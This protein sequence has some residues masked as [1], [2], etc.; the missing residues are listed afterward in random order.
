GHELLE[1]VKPVILLR[2]AKYQL[3]AGTKEKPK[4]G[5]KVRSL[6][7]APGALAL[8]PEEVRRA[9]EAFKALAKQPEELLGA[10]CKSLRTA[11]HPLVEATLREEKASPAFR[12]TAMLG[13]KAR[14]PE[15]LRL[16]RELRAQAS[17]PKLGAYQRWVR[18]LDVAEGSPQEFL[19]LDAIMRL[20]AG[21]GPDSSVPEGHLDSIQPWRPVLEDLEPKPEA[22]PAKEPADGSER[23]STAN[24][25]FALIAERK[26]AAGAAATPALTGWRVL[27]HEKAAERMPPN[28][29]D[30]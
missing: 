27:A 15:A 6:G 8:S 24:Q 9:T 28:H 25:L 18:E 4:P 14:W 5:P 2:A 30:L 7:A 23:K 11:L 16:L 17:R 29:Y 19:M 10:S 26:A 3:D 20:A 12:I 1:S 21:F 13:E 22:Q